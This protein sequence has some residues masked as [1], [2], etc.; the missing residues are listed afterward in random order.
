MVEDQK[1]TRFEQS[2]MIMILLNIAVIPDYVVDQMDFFPGWQKRFKELM[3]NY[4]TKHYKGN[5]KWR[6]QDKELEADLRKHVKDKESKD[7]NY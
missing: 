1:H 2:D 4:K 3:D 6:Y 5:T 7:P